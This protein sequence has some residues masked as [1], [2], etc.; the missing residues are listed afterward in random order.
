MVKDFVDVAGA[1][2]NISKT[3]VVIINSL[4]ILHICY[5]AQRY[6]LSQQWGKKINKI[7]CKF[8]WG[9][10]INPIKHEIMTLDKKERGMSLINIEIKAKCI[11]TCRIL[12]QF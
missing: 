8:L 5:R 3:K 6:L 9:S 11:F 1:S 2:L 7:I 10:A 4:L 12:K